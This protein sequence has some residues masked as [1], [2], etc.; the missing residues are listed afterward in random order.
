MVEVNRRLLLIGALVAALA[1]GGAVAG[2]VLAAGGGNG[3]PAAQQRRQQQQGPVNLHPVAGNFKPDRTKLSDCDSERCYEQ[4]FGDVAYYQGP[5]AALALFA[6]QMAA[7][8]AVEAG[9]HRIA[10]KIGS[11]TLVRDH[12]NI[13]KA[14]AAGSSICWSGY[15][16]GILERALQDAPRLGIVTAARKL[17]SGPD[18]RRT[19]WLAY[20]CVHLARPHLQV[21]PAQRRRRAE[22]LGD[23]GHRQAGAAHREGFRGR[24]FGV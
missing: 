11:A 12:G 9:C 3:K 23:P 22:R 21:H 6:Q 8:K 15:Y 18:V 16:H 10:H 20:Q 5:K 13:P 1:A 17:C 4:A 7:N 24:N 19:V 2:V 14:F